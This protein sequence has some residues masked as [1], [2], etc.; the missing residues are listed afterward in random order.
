[1]ARRK[2]DLKHPAIVDDGKRFRWNSNPPAHSAGD[3]HTKRPFSNRL[4]NRQTPW[5]SNQIAFSRSPRRPRNTNRWPKYGSCFR[6]FSAR[7]DSPL[8]PFL[9]VGDAGSQPDTRIGRNRDHAVRPCASRTTRSGSKAPMSVSQW[10]D[11][12]ATSTRLSLTTGRRFRWN[13]NLRPIHLDRQK[14]RRV[15]T[16][17]KPRIAT[18]LEDHVRIEAVTARN[19]CDG[20]F[21]VKRL[22]NN[23]SLERLR[24]AP[25]LADASCRQIKRPR[26]LSGH[27]RPRSREIPF[28]IAVNSRA[29]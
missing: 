18:P 29:N 12:R 25:P 10:L 20:D 3:G 28:S 9:R 19:R 14:Y 23:P 15:A 8:K 24:I 17:P 27:H 21:Q 4:E 1:M 16:R 7:A 5:P 26:N 2:S 11:E 13:S 6:T 22:G